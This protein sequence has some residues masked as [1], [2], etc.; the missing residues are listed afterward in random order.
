MD[1][2]NPRDRYI[3]DD[4]C[5]Y[6]DTLPTTP[7][8]HILDADT[9]ADICVIGG[10]LTGVMTAMRLAEDGHDVVLLERHRI[11]WGASGRTGGQLIPGFNKDIRTLADKYGLEPCVQAYNAT[12]AALDEVRQTIADENIKCE[13]M[14]GVVFPAGSKKAANDLYDYADFCQKHFNQ[15]IGVWDRAETDKQL[16][17][18]HYKGAMV[19]L[20]AARF[21][22]L[23]YLVAMAQRAAAKGVRIYEESPATRIDD[24]EF[25]GVH[26]YSTRARVAAKKIVVAGDAYL[27][28]LMPDLR[29]KVVLT[30][31]SMLATTVLTLDL[32]TQILPCNHAVC[33][34]KLLLNYFVKSTDGRIIF[35]GGDTP[36][37]KNEDEKQ[38]AFKNIN[39]M[40]VEVFPQL[41]NVTISHWWGGYLSM[42]WDEVPNVGCKDGKIYYSHGYSGHGIIPSHMVARTIAASVRGD[43]RMLKVMESFRARDI[44]GAGSH[45]S[46]LARLGLMWYRIKDMF[47]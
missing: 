1:F 41:A 14:P 43:P 5:L 13:F 33:E 4:L 2:I 3:T 17:T 11:G 37:T 38:A 25:T 29:R 47:G 28:W 36:L 45:D 19:D 34:W 7:H 15:Q 21:N 27:G 20:R 26:V 8:F 24:S 9:T 42:T 31:T 44:P 6:R 35:G 23:Q 16:G 18:N 10:G 12:L 46:A 32:L 40:M 39:R 22:P 30:R